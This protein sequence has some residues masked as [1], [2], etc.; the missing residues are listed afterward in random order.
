MKADRGGDGRGRRKD[1][2]TWLIVPDAT[3]QSMQQPRYAKSSRP[4][5]L[6]P[7]AHH[8]PSARLARYDKLDRPVR[9]HRN[10]TQVAI[11]DPDAVP[12]AVDDPGDVVIL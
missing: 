12:M 4:A 1:N 9:A 8:L 10:V 11:H 5:P 2:F 6:N 3:D 7:G